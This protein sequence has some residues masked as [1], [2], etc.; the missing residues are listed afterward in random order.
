MIRFFCCSCWK[1]ISVD[2][3][4]AGATVKCPRCGAVNVVPQTDES[5]SPEG[6]DSVAG[7]PPLPS[8]AKEALSDLSNYEQAAVIIQPVPQKTPLLPRIPKRVLFTAAGVLLLLAAALVCWLCLRDTWER[9]H[10]DR[11]V[12]LEKEAT[13]LRLDARF[14]PS[15][16]KYRE[17]LYLVGRRKIRNPDLAGVVRSAREG[18]KLARKGIEAQKSHG[19]YQR[20][21]QTIL[22]AMSKGRRAAERGQCKQAAEAYQRAADLM[23]KSPYITGELAVLLK[24][25]RAGQQVARREWEGVLKAKISGPAAKAEAA[26]ERGEFDEAEKQYRD[27]IG[28]VATHGIQTA[29]TKEAVSSW[30]IVLSQIPQ[31]RE[32]QQH[33]AAQKGDEAKRLAEKKRTQEAQIR[34]AEAELRLWR[35]FYKIVEKTHDHVDSLAV[36]DAAVLKALVE[37][38]AGAHSRLP[39]EGLSEHAKTARKSG[40]EVVVSVRAYHKALVV[41]GR[42]AEETDPGTKGQADATLE[43]Y[44]LRSLGRR[45][46]RDVV[47]FVCDYV[48][49]TKASGTGVTIESEELRKTIRQKW[50]KTVTCPYCRG[51]GWIDCPSC[52]IK[53]R[54]TGLKK[55]QACKGIG[56]ATCMVCKGDW[57]T[58]CA[59]C[60]GTGKALGGKCR[61]CNGTGWVARAK[62]GRRWQTVPGLCYRC[63]Y[64]P[65]ELRGTVPCSKC[66]GSGHSGEVCSAC[67]GTK[68]IPCPYCKGPTAGAPASQP[69]PR[70]AAESSTPL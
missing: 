8:S 26:L 51:A 60:K 17:L 5:T 19:Y 27:L 64:R 52:R 38:L 34:T 63:G 58:K 37:S 7:S 3:D 25:A 12:A 6:E 10:H 46:S 31:R 53:G 22:A 20:N 62:V 1:R 21:Q 70:P 42:G 65:L 50:R 66:L 18:V 14:E 39:A 67:G 61:P 43:K 45:V 4:A 47:A 11:I 44:K 36:A 30:Q 69:S 16:E 32:H 33:L 2:D 56:N 23:E 9:D 13:S 48:V 24:Q 28:F 68:R 57:G 55:C 59:K 41:L 35:E 15:V 40:G 29:R 54:S 49:F